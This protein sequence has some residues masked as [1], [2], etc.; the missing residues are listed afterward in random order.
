MKNKVYKISALII[1][2]CLFSQNVFAKGKTAKKDK[3]KTENQK[4][5][6]TSVDIYGNTV[7]SKEFFAKK[8]LT[9][10]NLWGTFCNPCIR[11]MPQL[12]QWDK[13]LP[14]NVQLLGIVGDVSSLEE[15]ETLNIMKDFFK[16]LDL[17]YVNLISSDSIKSFT[18]QFQYVP[19]TILVDKN[20]NVIGEPIVG[21]HVN[22]YKNAVENYLGKK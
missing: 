1:F 12:A 15:T 3:E 13:E 17:T 21:A 5:T 16:K 4:L 9:V 7:D 10:I 11:E 20:G 14:K 6:F 2:L 18:S 19:T 8:D 22:K